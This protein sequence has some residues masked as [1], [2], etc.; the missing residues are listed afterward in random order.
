[1]LL[2]WNSDHAFDCHILKRNLSYCYKTYPD[3]RHEDLDKI[4]SARIPDPDEDPILYNLVKDWMVHG[5]CGDRCK[6]E[7]GNC[8]KK[9][10][11]AYIRGMNV[12]LIIVAC[13]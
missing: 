1:M 7:S 11:R 4:I 12:V 6:D 13:N 9:F 8:S 5:P 10:P 3:I 2:S